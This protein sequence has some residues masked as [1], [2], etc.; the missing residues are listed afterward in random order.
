M[1]HGYEK[2]NQTRAGSISR[3]EMREK[4]VTLFELP[5]PT[6]DCDEGPRMDFVPGMLKLSYDYENEEGVSWVTLEFDGAIASQFIPDISVT[7][8]MLSAYSRV[9]ECL[10]SEWIA[11][12]TLEAQKHG[13]TFPNDRRHLFVYFDHAGC[14]EVLASNVKIEE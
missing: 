2:A 10:N 1:R 6:A 13:A 14:I 4:A 9:C 7:E 8:R 3:D 12:L 11:D 5:Y